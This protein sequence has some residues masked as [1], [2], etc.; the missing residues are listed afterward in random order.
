[1][2][3]NLVLPHTHTHVCMFDNDVVIH[4]LVTKKSLVYRLSESD[5]VER[6][7]HQYDKQSH[8]KKNVYIANNN[9]QCICLSS[10]CAIPKCMC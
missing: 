6:T 8:D 4:K 5:S 2:P 7:A 3:K 1:M 9:K 10:S